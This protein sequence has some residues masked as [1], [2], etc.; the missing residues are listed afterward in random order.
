M[1]M[2]LYIVMQEG[3]PS[4]GTLMQLLGREIAAGLLDEICRTVLARAVP[5]NA[6]DLDGFQEVVTCTELMQ[7]NCEPW[8]AI[9][10][11]N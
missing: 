1:K 6:K 5:S 7:G 2:F 10:T 9:L 4:G 11:H 3:N 8:I